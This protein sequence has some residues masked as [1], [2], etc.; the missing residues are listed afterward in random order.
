MPG[1]NE[2]LTFKRIEM[3]FESTKKWFVFIGVGDE[4]IDGGCLLGFCVT[5]G[6]IELSS[7]SLINCRSFSRAM[8]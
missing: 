7:A 3:G 2:T 4:N 8:S 1:G 6:S 5:E